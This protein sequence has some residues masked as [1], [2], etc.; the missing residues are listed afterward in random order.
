MPVTTLW[1]AAVTSNVTVLPEVPYAVA[2]AG[3]RFAT[4]PPAYDHAVLLLRTFQ[5]TAPSSNE[6]GM[7]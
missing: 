5:F 3:A 4:S 7:T 6:I 2:V 1:T